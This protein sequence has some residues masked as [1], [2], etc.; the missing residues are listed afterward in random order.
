MDVTIEP[1][2]A[3]LALTADGKRVQRRAVTGVV[4]GA[5]FPVVWVATDEDY[6]AAQGNGHRPPALPWP[7]EDVTPA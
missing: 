5:D 2:M 6:E 7:A 1:G 4:D 3:V